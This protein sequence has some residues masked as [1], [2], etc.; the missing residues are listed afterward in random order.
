MKTPAGTVTAELNGLQITLDSRS[1]SILQL[2]Y[3]GPGTI[4][5][6]SPERA[7]ILDLAYPVKDFEPLRLAPRFSADARIE[8]S[9]G[10]V[11]IRWDK[12]GAS[13]DFVQL[14]GSVS[15]VV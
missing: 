15:A 10:Q 12:L 6:S 4:L 11:T 5:K 1:G 7:G 9:P 2:S 8:K 3:P 13:R 14:E